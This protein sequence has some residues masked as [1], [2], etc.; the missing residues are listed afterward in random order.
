MMASPDFRFFPE[1]NRVKETVSTEYEKLPGGI[2]A[3][4]G[5]SAAGYACGIKKN[6]LP[7]LALI[8]CSVR[9]SGAAL[10]TSNRFQAAPLP[11]TREH[12]RDGMLQA[13]VINSGNANACT[14]ERGLGDARSMASMAAGA[15]GVAET[16]VAVASTGVIGVFL[17]MQTLEEGI[18]EASRIMTEDGS[19]AAQAILTTDTFVKEVAIATMVGG[20]RCIIGGMAKG[21]GMIRPDLATMLAFITTDARVSPEVLHE[22]LSKAAGASFNMISV[23]GC[24]STNDMVLALASGT[25]Q[26][27]V[28]EAAESS[29]FDEALTEVCRELAR[30]IV[31]DAEG[32]TKFVTVKVTGASDALEAKAAA[33]AVADSDLVK[34]A[35]FGQDANW[36][37]IAG[38]LGAA[39]IAFDPMLVDISLG[40]YLLLSGGEPVAVQESDLAAYM[41]NSDLSIL[42]DMHRGTGAATVWTSDLTYDYVR[43]NADYRS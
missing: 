8:R 6:G 1:E 42:V 12:L 2:C 40:D 28:A 19:A 18:S 26:A 21:A 4:D 23:D 7:D 20:E 17:P 36:G 33:M 30:L 35:L 38:A 27:R 34:T 13:V 43:I 41:V 29:E 24:M 16:D 9:A 32:A 5:F 39:G 11:V 3:P 10:Y 37:R 14:G 22:A 31:K 15:L 25:G